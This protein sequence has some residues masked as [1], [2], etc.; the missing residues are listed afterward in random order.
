[1]S[2]KLFGVGTGPGDPELLTL[3]A[4]RAIERADVVAYF[5]KKG[6]ASNARGIVAAY[7]TGQIEEEL[8]Y[9]VTTEIHRHH[10]H[11][12]TQIAAFYGRAAPWRC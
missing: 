1:M 7:L 5:A 2:G 11:Y 12:K 3:K 6:N 4:V 10:G 9:P 8:A